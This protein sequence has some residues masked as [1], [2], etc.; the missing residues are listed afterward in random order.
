ML[1]GTECKS[2]VHVLWGCS[3]YSNIRV[4]LV[5][6]LQELL[7]DRYADFDKLSSIEKT[8]YVLGSEL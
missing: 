2:V 6:K 1:Y 3:T 4:I 8:A 5:E 7:G